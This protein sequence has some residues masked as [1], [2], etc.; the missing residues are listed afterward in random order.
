MDDQTHQVFDALA[1]HDCAESYQIHT[2]GARNAPA[3]GPSRMLVVRLLDRGGRVRNAD[4]RFIAEMET[5]DGRV[6]P[7]STASD[8]AGAIDR[9]PWESLT[10]I[11]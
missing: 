11:S 2:Y 7:G 4:L 9:L 5:E 1:Q 3:N 6:Y 8:P 10:V